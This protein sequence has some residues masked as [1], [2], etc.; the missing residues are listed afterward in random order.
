MVMIK[1][2][3]I[4]NFGSYSN[5]TWNGSVALNGNTKEFQ[6]LN[7]IY[8]RNYSGKTNLS[9]IIRCLETKSLP[10]NFDNPSFTMTTD[11][12][13]INTTNIHTASDNIRVYNK[14]FIKSNLSFL[15]DH[16]EG[17]IKT[18]A[19]IGSDNKKIEEQI[20]NEEKKLGSVES[21]SGLEHTNSIKSVALSN[22]QKAENRHYDSIE[23]KLKNHANNVIKKN[24]TYGSP[25]YNI[26]KIKNDIEEI[27]GHSIDLLSESEVEN[28]NKLIKEETLDEIIVK[29][30]YK[31]KSIE[32][33]T[34]VKELIERK[35][36]PTSPIQDLLNDSILQSWVKAGIEHHKGKR[37]NCGFCS[38]PLPD[39]IWKKLD[40]HFNKASEDLENDI[41]EL[42]A[43]IETEM[44]SLQDIL[45]LKK[46]K[47][48]S[49]E[50]VV[51]ETLHKEY[52]KH[53]KLYKKQLSDFLKIL[54]KRKKD[55]FSQLKI[56]PLA[57][58]GTNLVSSIE[59]IYDLVK[60]NNEKTNTL[61]TDKLAA[62][63]KL[64][65]DNVRGF[66]DS[67][68]LKGEKKKLFNL[69]KASE[70]ADAEKKKIQDEIDKISSK[71]EKLKT[72][73]ND[74]K[75]GAE[76]VNDYLN[77]FFG[78]KGLH[79][80]ADENTETSTF[81]FQIMRGTDK[82]YNLSEGECSLIS[83][84]YFV[85]KLEDTE[86]KGK[87]MIVYIDDPISS[88]DSNHIFFVYSLI[89]SILAKP[90]KNDNGSNSYKYEQLFISTHNLDF[91]KYLKRLSHPRRNV[92]VNNKSKSIP[93]SEYFIIE[94]GESGSNISLMPNY[95]KDYTTEFNYLFHQIFL[96]KDAANAN[97]NHERFYSF[98]NNLRKFLEAFLFYKYPYQYD[99]NN[100]LERLTRFFGDDSTSTAIINRVSNELSHL[101]EI[102]DRSMKPIEVP[103]ITTLANFVL[104]KIFEKDPDQYNALL[105]SIGEPEREH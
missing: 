99:K 24:R 37:D 83:F 64:R 75:K 28:Y 15:E 85:A 4:Q 31:P 104:D 78:H 11:S 50:K 74:E 102:F 5:F 39:G 25:T 73:R 79:L 59:D 14:D 89:E 10:E 90:V 36:E 17:D 52:D 42:I 57:E 3:D 88:L 54:N 71:I 23:K 55:I 80:Q 77:H 105:K 18:F 43:L 100:S 94:G 63:N 1:K 51:F 45:G 53:L 16:S 62:I 66:V 81:K 12:N 76:K 40:N 13:V 19:I 96:C 47:F 98:G 44:D 32:F 84:C 60:K 9:R 87:D 35:I 69:E 91:F 26:S 65:I 93:D 6:R 22:A 21:K 103:E 34:Q 8:G 38:Q 30:Q 92:V 49:S 95:L 29:S 70:K 48:Y 58:N 67:I 68:D 33:H 82:A 27:R 7:I 46:D 61:E 72:Q 2:I 56:E 101:E 41:N 20:K 97:D 86:T